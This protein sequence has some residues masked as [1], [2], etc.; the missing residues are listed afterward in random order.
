MSDEYYERAVQ[1]LSE[2]MQYRIG[3]ERVERDA[4]RMTAGRARRKQ[5]RSQWDDG[6]DSPN[7]ETWIRLME[8]FRGGDE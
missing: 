4:R 2:Q 1:Y 3:V 5:H 6:A 7:R 8:D